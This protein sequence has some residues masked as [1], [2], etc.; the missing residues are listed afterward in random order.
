MQAYP[1]SNAVYKYKHYK[2]AT[3]Y[4]YIKQLKSCIKVNVFVN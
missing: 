2:L 1:N 3:F 4:L